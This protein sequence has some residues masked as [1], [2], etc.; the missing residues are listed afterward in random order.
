MKGIGLIILVALTGFLLWQPVAETRETRRV[1]T[2]LLT[3]QEALQGYLIEEELYPKEMMSGRELL[4]LLTSRD[5]LERDLENPWTR[6]PYLTGSGDDYLTYR[7]DSL[8]E[9]YE[10]TV[11]EEDGATVRFRL[12]STENQSL[13]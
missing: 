10:L 7:T 6:Q 8:A 12:D 9:T 3:V 11:F 4:D 5:F 2:L 13:E 1:K